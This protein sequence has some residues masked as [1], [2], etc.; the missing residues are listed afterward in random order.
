MIA[1]KI[2]QIDIT[3]IDLTNHRTFEFLFGIIFINDMHFPFT[4][5][6]LRK[7]SGLFGILLQ[8]IQNLDGQFFIN[9]LNLDIRP[10][11]VFGL[12]LGVDAK[13]DYFASKKDSFYLDGD[14]KIQ[15]MPFAEGY[16]KTRSEINVTSLSF[17][18]LA[19]VYFGDWH[20]SLGAEADLNLWGHTY[21]FTKEA[22]VRTRVTERKAKLETFSYGLIAAI[23]HN[24]F[25]IFCKYYPKSSKILPDGSVD[26][27]YWTL[28]LAFGL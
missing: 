19:K 17:P 9:L 23:Q 26:F 1:N 4:G 27:S 22:N 7:L 2:S 21:N 20:V 8:Q 11:E 15:A 10:A 3:C 25:G 24:D 28:G 12:G 13:F 18:L 16:D 5:I 14:K 6:G